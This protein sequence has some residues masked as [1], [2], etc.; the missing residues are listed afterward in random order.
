MVERIVIRDEPGFVKYIL[1]KY[2]NGD[3]NIEIN[4]VAAGTK[5]EI[6]LP[7]ECVETLRDALIEIA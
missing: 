1:K 4:R 6:Y 7:K 2:A 3:A 5:D